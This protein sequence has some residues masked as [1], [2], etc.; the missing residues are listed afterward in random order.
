MAGTGATFTYDV[1]I[2]GATPAGLTAAIRAS[3]EGLQTVIVSAGGAFSAAGSPEWLGPRAVQLCEQCG[4][5]GARAGARSF[6]GLRLFSWDLQRHCRVSAAGL[7]GWVMARSALERALAKIAHGHGAAELSPAE[8]AA[9][10]LSEGHVELRLRD[11]RVLRGRVLVIAD[12]LDSPTAALA[13]LP[14]AGRAESVA[15][16]ADVTLAA[17]SKEVGLDVVIGARRVPQLATIVRGP[18]E[19]R[20]SLMTRDFDTP[21][22]HQLAAFLTAARA[23]RLVPAGPEAPVTT[24]RTPAGAALD[25]ETHV[26]K[27]CLLI[28]EAG[29]FVAA[30]SNESAYPA[31]LSGWLA[32]E[33]AARALRAAVCQD[34]LLSF[35]A[36]WRAALA[37]YLRPPNT[38]LPLL[39][40]LVFNNPQMSQRVAR[41]F[42]LGQTF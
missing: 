36:T 15:A 33:S 3:Q 7:A 34:E 37:D 18:Q 42:L 24:G 19:L 6:S 23:A 14:E 1:I 22:A 4:V 16:C 29:G 5:R 35:S 13:R 11:G 30:F 40:P 21:A 20:V 27:R 39:I 28:G 17:R 26:G 8:P 12:G 32:A 9:V 2:V 25:L 10:T 38:D 41:A 31:M